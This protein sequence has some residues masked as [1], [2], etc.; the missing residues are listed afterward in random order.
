MAWQLAGI[1]MCY[2]PCL[3]I[4]TFLAVTGALLDNFFA[5]T[6]A[7][8]VLLAKRKSAARLFEL[9]SHLSQDLVVSRMDFANLAYHEKP[10]LAAA[11]TAA[12]GLRGPW[13]H[14]A[15]F[16]ELQGHWL[17]SLGSIDNSTQCAM[18]HV[19]SPGS[20]RY[21]FG[22][23]F[24]PA[25]FPQDFTRAPDIDPMLVKPCVVTLGCLAT[26]GGGLLGLLVVLLHEAT[27]RKAFISNHAQ[28]YLEAAR[29]S[30][31]ED[32]DRSYPSLAHRA[33]EVVEEQELTW[34][35]HVWFCCLLTAA[36]LALYCW[37]EPWVT[38]GTWLL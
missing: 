21:G 25:L 27:N 15:S 1:V 14:L 26:L 29:S 23:S 18:T 9:W 32:V 16:Q 12:A 13:P 5:A 24:W 28:A 4:M 6:P 31:V 33:E 10:V 7:C 8:M 34:F 22:D 36:L 35:L 38:L 17:A 20:S 2:I 3:K 11:G 19:P 37:L 30:A